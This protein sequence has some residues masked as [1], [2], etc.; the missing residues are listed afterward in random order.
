MGTM[1]D[2]GPGNG[3]L[4]LLYDDDG[5]VESPG[6][7]LGPAT[8]SRTG[9]VGRQVAGK[10]FLAAVF[11]HGS[12]DRLVALVRNTTSA[13][14]IERYFRQNRAS[15]GRARELTVVGDDA[16]LDAFFPDPPARVI[17][18][19]N[20]PDPRYAWARQHR[21]SDGFALCGVTH[22]LC[23]Q[24][25]LEWMGQLVTGPLEPYDALVCTSAAAL[26]MVRATT[27]HYADYL[28]E[29]VGGTPR[30]RVRL[31]VIPLG[32]DTEQFHPPSP[33]ER[34][35]RRE[36]LGIEHDEVTVLFVGRLSHHTKAHPFP[37]FTA[38]DRAARETGRK[39]RLVLSGWFHNQ[40]VFEAFRDGAGTFAPNVRTTIVD[41]SRSN[42]RHAVWHAADIFCSLSDNIQETFGLVIVEAMASGLPIVASDWDGYRDLVT[43]GE[44]GYLV[45]SVMVNGATHD[46][47]ARLVLETHS[48]DHFLAECSQAVAIDCAATT[49]AFVRLITDE[50]ERRRLGATAR[51]VALRRF[52]WAEVIRD[53]EALWREQEQ[54]RQEHERLRSTK[55]ST[56]GPALYPSPERAF[57]GYPTRWLDERDELTTTPGAADRL[58]GLL[59]SPLVTHA[60][61][62]R[63]TGPASIRAVLTAAS[64]GRPLTDLEAILLAE[65]KG[66]STARATVAWMLKYD[67]LQ[68]AT[69]PATGPSGPSIPADSGS[70]PGPA[71]FP[72]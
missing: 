66:Q 61:W 15:R 9:L 40:A 23:T 19:P 47:T 58:D 45:P 36:A 69:A 60:A 21:G 3:V 68:L 54:T 30:V 11:A 38:L 20:P 52:A 25:T 64:A 70:G 48:Y 14:T 71:P 17:Y 22:T 72:R 56:R 57:A 65:G 5:Y 28:R 27:E 4:G 1:S 34:L 67:L 37:M 12:W 46:A 44:S 26:R 16:F 7:P 53:Y 55:S 2:T 18:N 24:R 29:R 32:V 50:S 31:E 51:R 13:A 35:A 10:E 39:V 49:R 62:A 6:V 33:E 41:G 59:S 43:D 8:A 63:H 42:D